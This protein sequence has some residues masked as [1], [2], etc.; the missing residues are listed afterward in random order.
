MKTK[1]LKNE[2]DNLFYAWTLTLFLFFSRTRC[3]TEV[4][5]S[6]SNTY[7]C[8]SLSNDRH[9]FPALYIMS[10]IIKSYIMQYYG[11]VSFCNIFLHKSKGFQ[12]FSTI[13]CILYLTFPQDVTCGNI[14]NMDIIYDGMK[15]LQSQMAE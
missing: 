10:Y 3:L 4:V 14:Y 12:N 13:E 1:F 6:W 2:E 8:R 11:L 7:Y 9:L 15:C 5:S